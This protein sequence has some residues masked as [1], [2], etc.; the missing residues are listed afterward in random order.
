MKRKVLF[1]Y[2]HVCPFYHRFVWLTNPRTPAPPPRVQTPPGPYPQLFRLLLV[3]APKALLPQS[4]YMHAFGWMVRKLVSE[5]T[6]DACLM[7]LFY[8]SSSESV[9]W[10]CCCV[11]CV[12]R[13]TQQKLAAGIQFSIAIHTSV[14]GLAPADC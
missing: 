11:R 12:C 10:H 7:K 14:K 4:A 9:A 13:T 3:P 2:V 1:N 6:N 8:Q 5:Q